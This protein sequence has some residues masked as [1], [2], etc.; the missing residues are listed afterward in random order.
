MLLLSHAFTGAIIGEKIANPW[1]I[2]LLAFGS[3]FLLDW[4]P[5]WSYDVPEKMDARE[6]LKIVPDILPTIIIYLIFLY[7]FPELWFNIT[8]GVGLA[9]LPDFLT[10]TRYFT[11][12]NRIFNKFNSWHGRIQVHDYKILGLAT[13]IV[14]I[15]I[16]IIIL[17]SL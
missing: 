7:S 17:K 1:L 12:L 6:F 10:L 16:L 4:I 11:F 3:H 13:Q 2:G 15:G 9:I 14:Y 5:H 8:L